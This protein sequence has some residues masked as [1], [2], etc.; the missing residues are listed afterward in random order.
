[1]CV[2]GEVSSLSGKL[3]H[4]VSARKQNFPALCQASDKK[5]TVSIKIRRCKKKLHELRYIIQSRGPIMN[6]CDQDILDIVEERKDS[7]AAPERSHASK[8]MTMMI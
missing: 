8:T 1:M 3:S 5:S 7:T 6:C 4:D 2:F